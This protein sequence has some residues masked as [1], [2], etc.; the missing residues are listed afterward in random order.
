MEAWSEG[1]AGG[2][3]TKRERE[4]GDGKEEDKGGKR[5]R[6]EGQ[7]EEERWRDTKRGRRGGGVVA[8]LLKGDRRG[9][10]VRLRRNCPT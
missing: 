7:G 1:R 10:G 4:R 3:E 2:A 9:V 6:R 8:A 5:R